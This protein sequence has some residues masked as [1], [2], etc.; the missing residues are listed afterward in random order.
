LG[1]LHCAGGACKA[2][3]LDTDGDAVCADIDADDDGDGCTDTQEMGP[4]PA[5]GGMRNPAIVWDFYD[6]PAGDPLMRD[7][8]ISAFDFFALLGRFG[9]TGN[10][11]GHP[12]TPPPAAPAYHSAYDRS[13]PAPG[14]DPWDSG[15]ANGSI[16]ATDFFAL[17]A[18]FGHSCA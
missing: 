2:A 16:S 7:G 3:C 10:P 17:L 11:V 6:V 8:S 15:A 5:S 18:Q 9:S 4:T 14:G 13:S 1:V 12:L